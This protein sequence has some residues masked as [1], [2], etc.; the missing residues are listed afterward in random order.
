MRA[1]ETLQYPVVAGSTTSAEH[2]QSPLR[3]W[4]TTVGHA[5]LFVYGVLAYLIVLL[6]AL[7]GFLLL[8]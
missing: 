6:G 5:G 8:P 3:P 1:S 7:A 4:W 2:A